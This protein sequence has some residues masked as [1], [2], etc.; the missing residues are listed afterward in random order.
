MGTGSL[1]GACEDSKGPSLAMWIT[2]NA[3][4]PSLL[5]PN[6][7]RQRLAEPQRAEV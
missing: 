3:S 7:F 4:M 6:Y 5:N 1:V 2:L